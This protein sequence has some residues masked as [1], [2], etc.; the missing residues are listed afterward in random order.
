MSG[1]S[2]RP[3]QSGRARSERAAAGGGNDRHRPRRYLRSDTGVRLLHHSGG[4]SVRL[5]GGR[6]SVRRRGGGQ[7][8]TWSLLEAEQ[9]AAGFLPSDRT[10]F[11]IDNRHD[12]PA[13][14]VD[15]KRPF[16][17]NATV[18]IAVGLEN[19]RQLAERLNRKVVGQRCLMIPH[20]SLHAGTQLQ[21][22]HRSCHARAADIRAVSRI[23]HGLFQFESCGTMQFARPI[24]L[25]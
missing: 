2:G 13:G 6:M 7:C 24:P 8:G 18:Q 1:R 3:G 4:R 23:A 10:T 25:G 21:S 15:Q 20:D 14:I 5:V 12:A 11:E 17:A 22:K 16:A 9:P 19:S